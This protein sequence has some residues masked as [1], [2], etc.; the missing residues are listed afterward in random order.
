MIAQRLPRRR[1]THAIAQEG[2]RIASDLSKNLAA[3]EG[4]LGV[5]KKIKGQ[6][7]PVVD[8]FYRTVLHFKPQLAPRRSESSTAGKTRSARRSASRWISTHLEKVK[9]RH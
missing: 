1:R 7:D 8:E 3:M 6:T 2:E 4:L 9:M 5:A